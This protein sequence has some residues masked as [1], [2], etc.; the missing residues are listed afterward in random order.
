MLF[1]D[2]LSNSEEDLSSPQKLSPLA[3]F[4]EQSQEEICDIELEDEEVVFNVQKGINS[5][6]YNK[7]RYSVKHEKGVHYFHR[8]L[9]NY[10]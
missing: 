1:G 7:G 6:A 8:L 2:Y 10:I 3:H 5:K 4:T 9:T